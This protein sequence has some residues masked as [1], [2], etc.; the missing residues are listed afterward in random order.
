MPMRYEVL[1]EKRRALLPALSIF[2]KDFYLAGG[3]ALARR[4]E[5]LY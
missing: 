2:K 1:G 4:I 5:R 3:T